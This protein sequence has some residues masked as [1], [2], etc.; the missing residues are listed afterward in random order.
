MIIVIINRAGVRNS[1]M[2]KGGLRPQCFAGYAAGSQTPREHNVLALRSTSH[3][4]QK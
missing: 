1:L 4:H 2:L 3:G